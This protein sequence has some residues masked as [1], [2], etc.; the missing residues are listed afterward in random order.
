MRGPVRIVRT[1]LAALVLLLPAGCDGHPPQAPAATIYTG[2]TSG[3]Y[4]QYGEALRTSLGTAYR[5][6][7]V[8]PTSGSVD[9]VGRLATMPSGFAIVAA[10]VAAAAGSG[11]PPFSGDVPIRAVARLYDDYIHLVV[12]ANSPIYTGSQLRGYRV[13]LGGEGSGTQL[14]ADRVL[15]AD[16]LDVDRDLQAE[17]LD[18]TGSAAALRQHKIDAFFWSGGLPT[19]GISALAAAMPIRMVDLKP[20]ATKLRT[21]YGSSYRSGTIP[22]DTYP[23]GYMVTTIA[24]PNLLITS[25]SAPEEDIRRFT[26]ALFSSKG[27]LQ[28]LVPTARELDPSIAI[29]TEPVPLHPGAVDYYRSVKPAL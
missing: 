4:Y 16:G 24:I 19:P 18:L 12:P 26:A 11:Q 28:R 9:N 10:D 13:S 3:V 17:E 5:P 25:A 7:N 1:L 21:Q 20:E 22:A 14:I 8:V 15:T 27:A 2:G 6:L 29:Y 23:G